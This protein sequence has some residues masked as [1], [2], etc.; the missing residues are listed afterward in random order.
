MIPPGCPPWRPSQRGPGG[1][2]IA[3]LARSG[4]LD[5]S[6]RLGEIARSL[7]AQLLVVTLPGS[8]TERQE[9][10][11]LPGRADQW[12][13]ALTDDGEALAQRLSQNADLVVCW[14]GDNDSNGCLERIALASGVPVLAVPPGP[15][16]SPIVSA[17][18]VIGFDPIYR[19][20]DLAAGLKEVLESPARRTELAGAARAFCV[21]ASWQQIGALHLALWRTLRP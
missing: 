19:P 12:S 15:E 18:P 2:T 20:D 14:D 8:G 3:L 11:T 5:R 6:A 17:Y 1:R 9:G 13:A 4:D 21:E 10:G 7:A 16:V